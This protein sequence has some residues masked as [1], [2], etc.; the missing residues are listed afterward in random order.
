MNRKVSDQNNENIN[1]SKFKHYSILFIVLFSFWFL[2][3]GVTDTKFLI[4]GLVTALIATWVTGPLLQLPSTDGKGFFYAFDL[5]YLKYVGYWA[6]L[7]KEIIKANIDIL[8]ILINP[9][10]PINP[11]VIKFKKSMKNPL[12]HVTLGNSITLTPGTVT[13][14]I[15]GEDTYIIHAL[16]NEAAEALV[17]KVGEG[18]MQKRVSVLFGEDMGQRGEVQG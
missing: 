3:S 13:M 9:K 10:M 8:K 1:K 17:P 14:D 7:I 5:P 15:E 4:I 11:R 16:T 6:W 2:L 12:A 18:E